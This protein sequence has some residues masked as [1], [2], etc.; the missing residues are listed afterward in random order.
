MRTKLALGLAAV[1]AVAAL[2]ATLAFAKVE[3]P[4]RPPDPVPTSTPCA[5]IVA[6]NSGGIFRGGGL[7]LKFEIA[8]CSTVDASFTLV[9]TDKGSDRARTIDCSLS[10]W[11]YEPQVVFVKAGSKQ[12][13]S[14]PALHSG[15]STWERHTVIVQT[16]DPATGALL[17]G[18]SSSWS[19]PTKP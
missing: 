12:S 17:A 3:D 9:V 14:E 11:P 7:D 19:D 18:A 1:T 8:N 16:F 4:L 13:F 2:P 6:T 10:P 5:S 15:C